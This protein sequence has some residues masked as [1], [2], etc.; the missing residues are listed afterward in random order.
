MKTIIK[1]HN[2]YKFDELTEEGKQKAIEEHFNINVDY[3]WWD[4]IFD[5]AR[6]VGLKIEGFDLGRSQYLDIKFIEE[7]YEVACKIAE[8]HGGQCDT[9][10]TAK[11]FIREH[12]EIIDTAEKDEN[13]DFMDEC[14]IDDKL[15]EAE[16]EF[17][18]SISQDYFYILRREYDYLT[19]EEVIIDT[20]QANEY[21]FTE[22]GSIFN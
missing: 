11:D 15:D 10:N 12:D 17:L 1:K 18:K 8:N 16:S 5:D 14:A 9:V 21:D 13:G 3:E 4:Y 2:V 19:S 20:L 22:D 7:P 6:Q